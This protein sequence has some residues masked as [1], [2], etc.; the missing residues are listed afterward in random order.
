LYQ[1]YIER[2]LFELVKTPRRFQTSLWRRHMWG[3]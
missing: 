2:I 1:S 3:K